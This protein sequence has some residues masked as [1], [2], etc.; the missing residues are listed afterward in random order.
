MI[1]GFHSLPYEAT[2]VPDTLTGSVDWMYSIGL[3][4]SPCGKAQLVPSV[5]STGDQRVS[6]LFH[7]HLEPLI[8][9]VLNAIAKAKA[10]CRSEVTPESLAE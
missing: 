9:M 1:P 7:A 3:L 10:T 6:M 2:T 5:Q 4:M 8:R